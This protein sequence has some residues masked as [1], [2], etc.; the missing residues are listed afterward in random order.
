MSNSIQTHNLKAAGQQLILNARFYGQN[1]DANGSLV[2]NYRLFAGSDNLAI[3]SLN[4][5]RTQAGIPSTTAIAISGG[6]V[7]YPQQNLSDV[8][9]IDK[10]EIGLLP[11]AVPDGCI[12]SYQSQIVT[13]D[14]GNTNMVSAPLIGE[15]SNAKASDNFT[16][17]IFPADMG[18]GIAQC[19]VTL[20]Q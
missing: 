8:Y 5:I 19:R 20:T 2:S 18:A 16:T 14:N 11:G 7:S 4:V 9:C 13:V 1:I 10:F 3:G 17:M 15:H 12:P 6:S